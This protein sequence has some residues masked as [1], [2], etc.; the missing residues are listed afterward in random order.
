MDPQPTKR[1]IWLYALAFTLALALRL[2]RLGAFPLTDPEA[3]AALQALSASHGAPGA[4]G[5]NSAYVLLTSIFFFLFEGTNFLARFIPALAGSFLVL[6]P[7][8]F[9]RVFSP[10]ASLVL[11]FFLVFDPGLLALSRQAGSSILAVTFLLCAL[12]LWGLGHRRLPGVLLALAVLSGPAVWA[13]LLGLILSWAIA[14]GMRRAPKEAESP[15]D[16]DALPLPGASFAKDARPVLIPFVVT[17][18]LFGTLIFLLP[19]GL[20]GTFGGLLEYVRGW[21]VPSALPGWTLLLSIPF[22]Q[23]LFLILGLI[24]LVRGWLRGDGLVIPLS[25]WLLVALLLAVFY[26]AH[27]VHDLVWP[28]VPLLALAALELS[29]HFDLRREERVEVGGVIALS[30]LVFIFGWL[31]LGTLPWNPGVAGQANLRMW[32]LFGALLLL[33]VSLLLVAVG[34]SARTARLGAVWGVA[35]FFGLFTI[36]AALAAGRV[37]ANY[38]SELWESGPYPSQLDILS[39][40]IS[41]LSEWSVG[42]VDSQPVTLY[43]TGLPSLRWGLRA[44]EVTVVDALD[45]AS[46]PPLLIT[47]FMDNP[48]LAASYRGQDFT[49]NQSPNWDTAAPS[50]WLRWLVVRDMPQSYNTIMLWARSDLFLDDPARSTP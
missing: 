34:W 42:Q 27:Q 11:A 39:S 6:V 13:G 48:G 24:S 14:Q 45:P 5:P 30:V 29:R 25:T 35:L 26:P 15:P 2:I 44:H 12:G 32:L 18:V 31:D 36:S 21:S 28:L 46:S 3:A 40:S 43:Q 49:W 38:T 7:F 50:D 33:V 16:G 37:R 23:P 22:Y 17:L 20:S 4:I 41:D 47:P 8:L 10:S 19:G 1:E 9:R